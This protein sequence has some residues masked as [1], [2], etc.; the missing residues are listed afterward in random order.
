MT[1]P[2]AVPGEPPHEAGGHEQPRLVRV[3]DAVRLPG[4]RGIARPPCDGV[5][6]NP[7]RT[8]KRN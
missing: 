8:V 6:V 2:R 5:T 3:R 1:L 4:R 7:A